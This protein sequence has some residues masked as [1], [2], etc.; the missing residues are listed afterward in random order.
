ME[1]NTSTKE[2]LSNPKN[3][4]FL[5]SNPTQLSIDRSKRSRSRN[6]RSRSPKYA[7]IIYGVVSACEDAGI[8]GDDADLCA[9]HN[10]AKALVGLSIEKEIEGAARRQIVDG[11]TA[12]E[13]L[14]PRLSPASIQRAAGEVVKVNEEQEDCA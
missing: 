2:P 5:Q 4:H 8:D 3:L 10:A 12:C 1:I 14:Q 6:R 11:L 7:A 9:V 13:R